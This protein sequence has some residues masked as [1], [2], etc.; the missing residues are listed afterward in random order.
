MGGRYKHFSLYT[1]MDFSKIKK[2]F[3]R[4]KLIHRKL[5]SHSKE[6]LGLG[7]ICLHFQAGALRHAVRTFRNDELLIDVMLLLALPCNIF[8]IQF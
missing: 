7:P 2:K 3:R 6:I 5:K 4:H 8:K 1:S